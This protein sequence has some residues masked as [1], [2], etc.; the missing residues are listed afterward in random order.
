MQTITWWFADTGRPIQMPTGQ[1]EEYGILFFSTSPFLYW[2]ALTL[3]THRVVPN[4][5]QSSVIHSH[6]CQEI[7]WEL[8]I[9]QLIQVCCWDVGGGICCPLS[10]VTF[11]MRCSWWLSEQHS[12]SPKHFHS[13]RWV[14]VSYMH[15]LVNVPSSAGGPAALWLFRTSAL[16]DSV[17]YIHIFNRFLSTKLQLPAVSSFKR[18]CV[19]THVQVTD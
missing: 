19:S 7:E 4:S 9:N 12:L 1:W 2:I 8:T 18:K 3:T 15:C 17:L 11:L 16:P 6:R 13:G 5:H 14:A 10:T